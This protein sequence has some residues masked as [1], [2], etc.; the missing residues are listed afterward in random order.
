VPTG[1]ENK[2]K[3]E[4]LTTLLCLAIGRC[5][6]AFL[7][8]NLFQSIVCHRSSLQ[9]TTAASISNLW[10]ELHT[11]LW[12]QS[13]KPAAIIRGRRSGRPNQGFHLDITEIAAL[14]KVGCTARADDLCPLR[15]KMHK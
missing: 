12:D 1:I 11:D 4:I 2:P 8:E 3:I 10:L 5:Y 6:Y 15:D 7:F 14:K 9:V 13:Y